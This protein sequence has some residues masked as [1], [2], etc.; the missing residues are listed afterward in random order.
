MKRFTIGVTTHN[1]E[2]T[3]T[4]L[5]DALAR[6]DPRKA[7]IIIYDDCSTDRTKEMILSH[8]VSGQE[9]FLAE[10]AK[11]NGGT[12]SIG[13]SF[14][15]RTSKT[16]YSSLIDGD[17]MIVP[18]EYERLHDLAPSGYDF[19]LTKRSL[20][21]KKIGIE[22]EAREVSLDESNVTRIFSGV[23][24]KSYKTSLLAMY[25][26]DSVRGRS[27]DVRL[28]MRIIEAGHTRF[29]TIPDI[30]YYW[31]DI[32]RKSMRAATL[33]FDE[34]KTRVERHKKLAEIYPIGSRY[35]KSTE[36]QVR[37]VVKKDPSLS[38]KE[39]K[40]MWERLDS[41]FIPKNES[42]LAVFVPKKDSKRICVES[43][44][45]IIKLRAEIESLE[46]EREQRL[47]QKGR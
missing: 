7:D 16:E 9:N 2:Q 14:I 17:D 35:I 1:E 23:A 46:R 32:S 19:I 30:C 33:N 47:R 38:D 34:M 22:G 31:T 37:L 29:F 13:R 45:H 41:I 15:G 28:N 20:R 42:S 5:L 26:P 3:I 21:G 8:P 6:L 36:E 18:E 39:R 43:M 24:G 4:G 10:F 12:P 44:P 25:G 40:A 27:D 11:T